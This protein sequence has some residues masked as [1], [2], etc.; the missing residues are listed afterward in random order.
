MYDERQ[1]ALAWAAGLF[2]GEG[3]FSFAKRHGRIYPNA[4]VDMT[5]EDVIRK[6]A[7]IIG[8]GHVNGPYRPKKKGKCKPHWR[9]RAN[10]HRVVANIGDMLRPWLGKRRLERLAEILAMSNPDPIVDRWAADER[11]K[12]SKAYQMFGKRYEELG[13]AELKIYLNSCPSRV[14]RKKKVA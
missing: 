1:L 13:A 7:D 11:Y 2:E 8:E 3:C 14:A 10:G 9:W 12:K 5:D 4:I 6:F